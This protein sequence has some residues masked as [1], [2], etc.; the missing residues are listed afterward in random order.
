MIIKPIRPMKAGEFVESKVVFPTYVQPKYDG[1]RCLVSDGVAL[2][3]ALKPFP[4]PN[5]QAFF[6]EHGSLLE[7]F[8]GELVCGDPNKAD[9]FNSTQNGGIMADSGNVDFTLH[10]FDLW[11]APNVPYITRLYN[12]KYLIE[13]PYNR[14]VSVRIKLA[15]TELANSLKSL[16]DFEE[17]FVNEGYEGVIIKSPTGL[18]KHG[19]ST[20]NQGWSQKIKRF[21]D[22]EGVIVGFE[23][24]L[25]NQNEP[26]Q[27]AL[28]HQ[29]RS[30]HQAGK[31]PAGTLGAL[32]LA[33]P[34]KSALAT[35]YG[36]IT[37]RCGSGFDIPTRQL[38]WNN[39]D[40]YLGKLVRF[41]YF[42]VGGYDAPRHPTFLSFRDEIDT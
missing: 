39:R 42:A 36:Q 5:L 35:S 28:G 16:M 14:A 8:D 41:K 30:S 22:A 15:R 38:I 32:K 12:L 29:K 21:Q 11:D 17:G 1:Y 3:S 25:I 23:E 4:N 33:P 27:D 10:V 37:F 18:Y 19:R 31:V 26:I 20:V 6:K 2:S 40:K 7:G 13:S 24:L 34:A 9:T